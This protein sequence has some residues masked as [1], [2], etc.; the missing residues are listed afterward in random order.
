MALTTVTG[1]TVAPASVTSAASN[2]HY[3]DTVLRTANRHLLLHEQFLDAKPIPAH[4]GKVL[5]VRTRAEFPVITSALPEGVTPS[6]RTMTITENYCQVYQYGDVAGVTDLLDMTSNDP[7]LNEI[8]SEQSAQMALSRDTLIRDFIVGDIDTVYYAESGALTPTSGTAIALAAAHL[9]LM[10]MNFKNAKVPKVT[11][12]IKPGTGYASQPVG[13]GWFLLGSPDSISPLR[14]DTE[15]SEVEYYAQPGQAVE[16]EVGKYRDIRCIECT[17][18]HNDGTDWSNIL[19]GPNCGVVTGLDG[20]SAKHYTA[21][22]GS[23]DDVL[24]QRQKV[25]W[26]MSLGA[27]IT[28]QSNILVVKTLMT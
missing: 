2:Q 6:A 18:L 24:H 14:A 12:L 26:K 16:G 13:A 21:P 28:K 1:A 7:V 27:M 20:M 8:V 15:W 23:G 19:W 17:N 10:I 9:D 25:G 5:N 11:K 4:T 3:Y 22:F